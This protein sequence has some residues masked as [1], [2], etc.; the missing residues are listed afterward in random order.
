MELKI[1]RKQK[2]FLLPADAVVF[3]NDELHVA[4]LK[5]G[6]VQFRKI[7]IVHDL[8]TTVQVNEGVEDGD[9]VIRTPAV[10]L[11]DGPGSKRKLPR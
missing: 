2:L 11:A 4:V 8:G 1:P 9:M 3:D 6:V 5:D 10:N 7:N